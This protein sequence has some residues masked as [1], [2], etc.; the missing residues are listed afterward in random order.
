MG[1]VSPKRRSFKIKKKQKRRKKI[2]KLK[3]MLMEAKTKEE[4]EEILRKIERIA[5][6]YPL[7]EL[8]SLGK[9]E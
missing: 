9:K 4:R 1:K 8:A 2:K 6:D 3:K 5:P 7:E